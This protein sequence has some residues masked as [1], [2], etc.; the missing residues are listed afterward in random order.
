MACNA[1]DDCSAHVP[2]APMSQLPA[3]DMCLKIH[4]LHMEK[5]TSYQ[6]SAGMMVYHSRDWIFM[7]A[8]EDSDPLET[9]EWLDSLSSVVHFS[10]R[11]RGLDLL[12]ALSRHAQN[13]GLTAASQSY[14]AYRNTI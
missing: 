6:E 12:G 2:V 8:L 13:L 4:S 5:K 7:R 14:S 11:K 3:C 10:G 9:R 1:A